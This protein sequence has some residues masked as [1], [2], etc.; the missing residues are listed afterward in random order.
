MK[1]LL[2]ILLSCTTL[3]PFCKAQDSSYI[4]IPKHYNVVKFNPTPMLLW[5]MDNATFSYERIQKYRPNQSLIVSAGYLILPSLLEGNVLNLINVHSTQ[6]YGINV[7]VDYR[8]YLSRQNAQPAPSGVYLSPFL[9]YYGYH[10]SSD[11]ECL[12]APIQGT[13]SGTLQVWNLGFGLGYQFVIAKRITLDF[14]LLAPTFSHYAFQRKL[15]I[16]LEKE[17]KDVVNEEINSAIDKHFPILGTFLNGDKLSRTES[18]KTFSAGMRYNVQFGF[19][20]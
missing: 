12:I 6:K 18:G 14:M 3:S 9:S 8:F 15:D 20:F 1:Y 13:F 19:K 10:F 5:N 2:L 16:E 7:G 4:K 17:D 11:V